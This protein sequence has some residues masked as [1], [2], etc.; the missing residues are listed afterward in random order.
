VEWRRARVRYWV[1]GVRD[2][3]MG[4]AQR[5]VHCSLAE[6]DMDSCAM[7]SLS[8]ECKLTRE[9][10]VQAY[11]TSPNG[12]EGAS[13]DGW[14]ATSKAW[15]LNKQISEAIWAALNGSKYTSGWCA[16]SKTC[17]EE[18]PEGLAEVDELGRSRRRWKSA[19][20]K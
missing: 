9:G 15:L 7:R 13:A 17:M 18:V 2:L 1:A 5:G 19:R 3:N 4:Q 12:Y 16:A 11:D 10:T 14:A 6:P 8:R 20:V